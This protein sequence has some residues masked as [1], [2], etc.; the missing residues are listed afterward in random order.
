MQH[1]TSIIR[2]YSFIYTYDSAYEYDTKYVLEEFVYSIFIC[3][4]QMHYSI[5]GKLVL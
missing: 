5:Q 4:S 3:M 1:A 2:V